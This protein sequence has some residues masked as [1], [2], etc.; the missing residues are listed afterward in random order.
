[1]S[2]T[3]DN[4]HLG[5]R[6]LLAPMSG[7]TDAPFR[8]LASRLGA[9][10]VITEMVASAEFAKQHD[11][12]MLKA[13]QA[14]GRGPHAVQLAGREAFWMAEAARAA[15]ANGANIIDINMG[16]PAKKVTGSLSGSALMRNLDHALELIE[17]TIAAVNVPVTLKMR[18]GWDD[19]NRNAPELARRA[20]AAGVSMITVHGRTRCQFYDGMAD[21]AEVARVKKA[22]TVPV[23]VNGDI[24]T[25]KDL[26]AALLASGA[27]GAM[28]GRGAYGK[29]WLPG[30]LNEHLNGNAGS[31]PNV[32]QRLALVLEHYSGMLEHYGRESG[33]KCARKHLGWYLDALVEA[34]CGPVGEDSVSWR[35]RLCTQ[36]DPATV[37][38][39]LSELHDMC[40]GR[41]AA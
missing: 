12:M 9:A 38:A 20:E 33:V 30:L 40:A 32:A 14:A 8:Q 22:V 29:P 2:I 3:I 37:V 16:C 39:S 28:I 6:V 24:T 27:D 4:I 13:K 35:R 1:M 26:Q 17:A 7:V 41:V 34:G 5:G 21:W 25:L 15:E 18:L 11:V 10:L 36:D 19:E 31:P 23:I